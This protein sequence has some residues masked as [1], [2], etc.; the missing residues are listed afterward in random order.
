M[1][2]DRLNSKKIVIFAAKAKII[3][4]RYQ[5]VSGKEKYKLKV[6]FALRCCLSLQQKADTIYDE[7]QA[8]DGVFFAA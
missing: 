3:T 6:N 8:K 2:T 7:E 4:L 5:N 1:A